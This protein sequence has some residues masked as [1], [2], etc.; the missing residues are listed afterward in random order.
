MEVILLEDVKTLGKKGEVVKVNEGYGR[1]CLL[2]KNLAMEATPVN[3]NNLKLKNANSER[4]AKEKLEEAKKL[5]I[6]LK[7]LSITLSI[8]TGAGGKTFGS[9]SG[10]EI[11]QAVKEQLKLDIDKKKLHIEEP[12]KS[13]GMH[14][15]K[16]KIHPEV[17]GELTV[18]VV[19][20]K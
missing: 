13:L 4:I 11:S 8:K 10:K 19:E 5:A 18:K 1:N 3:L 15:V 6:E 2:K 16:V 14:I 17:M 9:I 12:I 20:E 7:E